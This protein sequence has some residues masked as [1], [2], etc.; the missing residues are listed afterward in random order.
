[1]ERLSDMGSRLDEINDRIE[2]LLYRLADIE[3]ALDP[4]RAEHGVKDVRR[5]R[6]TG[7]FHGGGIRVDFASPVN[8]ARLR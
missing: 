3:N 8:P 7:Q 6:A 4:E 2:S 5:N 1:H